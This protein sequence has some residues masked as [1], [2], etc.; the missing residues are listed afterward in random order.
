L[1]LLAEGVTVMVFP[2][3]DPVPVA[4]GLL[5][6][7]EVPPVVVLVV[8][9][10]EL[11]FAAPE[12]DSSLAD[13]LVAVAIEGAPLV[14]LPV[15]KP[16]AAP[17]GPALRIAASLVAT[18]GEASPPGPLVADAVEAAPVVV[19]PVEVVALAP[20]PLTVPLP[21][22]IIGAVRLVLITEALLVWFEEVVTDTRPLPA[23]AVLL[24]E[25][26]TVCVIAPVGPASS[27]SELHD[28]LE[29]AVVMVSPPV[30]VLSASGL[31]W[32]DVLPPRLK[33]EEDGFTVI[34]LCEILPKPKPRGSDQT[35]ASP[36]RVWLDVLETAFAQAGPL[37]PSSA[38][39]VVAVAVAAWP[40]VVDVVVE[41]A[42]AGDPLT[43]P[44]PFAVI[45]ALT[46]VGPVD[47]ELACD[48]LAV[49]VV[50]PLPAVA[51]LWTEGVTV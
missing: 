14:A 11:A 35:Q 42:L 45:P 20:E 17:L 5:V 10:F 46:V 24:V 22:A 13:P 49:M 29:L 1:E 30:A 25:G 32:I 37:D 34:Q 4:E 2:L 48:L 27:H 23:S 26:V 41:L 8:V 31:T 50:A 3:M 12:P 33:L 6:V 28:R 38:L 40:V 36:P 16:A 43:V 7:L 39:P 19:L 15:V 47:A 51:V 18:S 44:V 9:E 21:L